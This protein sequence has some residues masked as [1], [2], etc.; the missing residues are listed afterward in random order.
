MIEVTVEIAEKLAGYIDDLVEKR[1]DDINRRNRERFSRKVIAVAEAIK[2]RQVDTVESLYSPQILFASEDNDV[3]ALF[4]SIIDVN[5]VHGYVPCTTRLYEENPIWADISRNGLG[6]KQY[7]AI[8]REARKL[9]LVTLLEQDPTGEKALVYVERQVVCSEGVLRAKRDWIR[10]LGDYARDERMI[11]DPDY[12]ACYNQI[13]QRV[14]V[15]IVR[16]RLPSVA[17]KERLY[18]IANRML[19]HDLREAEQRND[20]SR[21]HLRFDLLSVFYDIGTSEARERIQERYDDPREDI[22]L[23]RQSRLFVERVFQ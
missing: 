11:R 1:G 22:P 3:D 6:V 14:N 5:K 10:F 2:A 20:F 4:Y 18:A 7:N 12:V 9:I 13:T 8:A 23:K 19:E 17:T 16:H 21:Y 15:D